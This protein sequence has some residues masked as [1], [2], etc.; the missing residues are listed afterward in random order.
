M[1]QDIEMLPLR[2]MPKEIDAN[3]F[4]LARLALVR[5]ANPVRVSLAEHRCLEVIVSQQQWVC[6][7]ACKN[8]QL[9]MA[10]REFDMQHRT[11]LHEPINCK[12]YLYHTHASLIMGTAPDGL[13]RSLHELLHKH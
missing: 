5:L 10:W 6:V 9:I 12:L 8:D 7:D 4:N 13:A 1:I 3:T 11:A 2:I